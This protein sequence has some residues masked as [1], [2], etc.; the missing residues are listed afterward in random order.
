MGFNPCCGGSGSLG[1]CRIAVDRK[2]IYCFNPCCGGSG[3]LGVKGR[4]LAAVDPGVSI[5]VVV[6]RA[7]WAVLGTGRSVRAKVF[8][9]LLWW[10]G[11]AGYCRSRATSDSDEVSILVVVDRARWAGLRS[12]IVRELLEYFNPCCGGSGS[13]GPPRSLAVHPLVGFQ[14]LLWWIGLA[15][16]RPSPLEFALRLVF[17]SLLWWIGLAGGSASDDLGRGWTRALF[18]SLLWWIGLAGP[19]RE[20]RHDPRASKFQSLLWWIGL[21]GTRSGRHAVR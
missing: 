1:Q 15:G 5:L 21:A 16:A 10:I 14:S 11:L 3:S 9:S 2:P 20:C 17:Q 7:R 4:L 12:M 8:Q 19:R 13:L 18:Q 6:D